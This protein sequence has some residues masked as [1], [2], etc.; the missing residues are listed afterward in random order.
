MERGQTLMGF[1]YRH[2][3]KKVL[4]P[5][6]NR[7]I[8]LYHRHATLGPLSEEQI[9]ELV[10]VE[11]IIDEHRHRIRLDSYVEGMFAVMQ[12]NK[13]IAEVDRMRNF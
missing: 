7:R 3:V 9:E 2:E 13:R 10:K 12:A 1:S 6:I 11:S 5:A 8:Q 4:A